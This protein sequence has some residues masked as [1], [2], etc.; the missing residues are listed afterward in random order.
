MSFKWPSP[1]FQP[2]TA[3]AE[4]LTLHP[5]VL[6]DVVDR[7]RKRLE[8]RPP[9]EVHEAD[10]RA[11]SPARSRRSPR[12]AQLRRAARAWCPAAFTSFIRASP[13]CP[14]GRARCCT[15][16]CRRSSAWRAG[17]RPSRVRSSRSSGTANRQSRGTRRAAG[18]RPDGEHAGFRV[19]A[20]E[21]D[22]AVDHQDVPLDGHAARVVRGDEA[23]E[24]EHHDRAARR[25]A[26]ALPDSRAAG[27]PESCTRSGAAVRHQG[28]EAAEGRRSSG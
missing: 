16:S 22:A 19:E 8:Q 17:R 6:F 28:G 5:L 14:C 23:V 12:R 7:S 13:R 11:T 21:E 15:P 2:M 26:S 9:L 1:K 4:D 3:A 25:S 27:S 10:A 18:I 24:A 20:E